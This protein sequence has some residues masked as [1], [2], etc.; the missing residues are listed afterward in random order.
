[1]MTNRG[2]FLASAAVSAALLADAKPSLA[3]AGDPLNDGG[4]LDRVLRVPARHRMIVG[5]PFIRSASFLQTGH[6]ETAY[7]FVDGEPPGTVNHCILL[8]GPTSVMMAMNDTFW[9]EEKAFELC[10]ALNDFPSVLAKGPVNPFYKAHSSMNPHDDPEDLNG[11]Y[12]DHTIEALTKRGVTW[13]ICANAMRTAARQMSKLENGAKPPK[14]YLDAM[15]K[16]TIPHSVIAP[17]G[18]Q[19][20]VK[21]QELH[22][23]YIAAH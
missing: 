16:H 23:A 7:Q 15:L 20:L 17:S 5:A 4:P 1:M 2:A 3:A 8:Y 18:Y 11:F 22:F 10:T 21:A 13:L 19:T 14:Y 12:L 6:A 9:A